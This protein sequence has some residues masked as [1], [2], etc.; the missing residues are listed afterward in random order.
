MK[1]S[2]VEIYIYILIFNTMFADR[3]QRYSVL[4]TLSFLINYTNIPINQ[5]NFFLLK[6][7]HSFSYVQTLFIFCSDGFFGWEIIGILLQARHYDAAVQRRKGKM[8]SL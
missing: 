1:R 6:E 4:S 2:F 8:S 7:R 5:N 3:I